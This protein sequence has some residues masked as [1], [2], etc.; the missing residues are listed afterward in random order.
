MILSER[1]VQFLEP[2][3]SSLVPL[4]AER[5]EHLERV[6]QALDPY[7]QLV[8]RGRGRL[9]VELAAKAHRTARDR[10]DELACCRAQGSRPANLFDGRL[11]Q[12]RDQ[13]PKPFCIPHFLQNP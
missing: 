13:L 2:R 11:P 6:A 3:E 10:P 4:S 8:K 9:V 12:L 5:L 1:F 7:S